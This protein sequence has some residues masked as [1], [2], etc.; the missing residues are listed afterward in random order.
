MMSRLVSLFLALGF[1]LGSVAQDKFGFKF[2]G[3]VR[4]ELGYNSRA[5]QE[6]VDGLF[7]M[8]PLDKQ[9]DPDG[10]DLNA[11]PS[12]NMYALYTRLGVDIK[13]PSIGRASTSAMVETDF[14]GSGTGYAMLRMRQAYVSLDWG[15]DELLIG[16]TWHPM[17]GDVTPTMLNLSTGAPF[18][19]FSRTPMVRYRSKGRVSLTGAALWQMQYNSAGP[20][21]KSYKYLKNS[22]VPEIYAGVDFKG[23]RW[24]AGL[25]IDMISIAPRQ[26]SDTGFKVSERSTSLSAEAHFRYK[27]D[28]WSVAAKNILGQ[29]MAHASMLG[30]YAVSKVDERTGEQEYTSYRHNSTW[31]NLVYGKKWQPALFVG[32]TKNLGTPKDIVGKAYGTGLDIDQLA[33]ANVSFSYNLP[34]WKVGAELSPTVAWYGTPDER[35]RVH[36]THAV[37]NVRALAVAMYIF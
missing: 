15:R 21:G 26:K 8:F 9:R 30:G 4:A 32:Y 36:G 33:A 5:S 17:T 11:V 10:K 28:R 2:Y 27:T 16:Q 34:H 12:G 29:N 24:Q 23:R 3:R 35:G 1:S 20:D 31:L 19:P 14:R 18:Q 25:G 6:S 7:Y 22:C 13:G 37:A